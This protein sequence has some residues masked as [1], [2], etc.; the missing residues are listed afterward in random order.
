MQW[1]KF[2]TVAR[3]AGVAALGVVAMG[4]SNGVFHDPWDKVAIAVLAVATYFG[5]YHVDNKDPQ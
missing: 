5:V 1:H 4:L 2:L 3:K